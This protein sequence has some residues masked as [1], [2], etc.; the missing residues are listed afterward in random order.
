[1]TAEDNLVFRNYLLQFDELPWFYIKEN[2]RDKEKQFDHKFGIYHDLKTEK[3]SIWATNIDFS[4]PDL[5]IKKFV[6][7]ELLACTNYFS[8]IILLVTP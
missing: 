8:R 1:M 7:K 2:I 3:F 5:I 4:E 6:T